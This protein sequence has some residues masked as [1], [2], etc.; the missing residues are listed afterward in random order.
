MA[1]VRSN[2][3]VTSDTRLA[4]SIPELKPW[5]ELGWIFKDGHAVVIERLGSD[6]QIRK[7]AV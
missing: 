4:E 5:R 1:S 2:K 7:V 3:G 6:V